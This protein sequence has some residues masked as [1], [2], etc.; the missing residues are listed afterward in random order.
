MAETKEADKAATTE[1]PARRVQPVDRARMRECEFQRTVYTAT[2][3]ENTDPKDL[4]DPEYWTHVA[5]Q[6]KPFDKVEVR[7]DDG[8]WY[9]EL[10]VLETSRRWTRMHMLSKHNLTTGDV[11]LSQSKLQEYAVE[12][13]GPHKKH[14]V[15]RLSDQEIIHEGEETKGGA[16]TWLA[17]RIKA[18]L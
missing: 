3:F 5:E 13:K 16:H 10:L 12:F 14:C 4:L 1:T 7:A 9:A 15:I 18:G 6:F 17:G 11:S 8:S 2:A